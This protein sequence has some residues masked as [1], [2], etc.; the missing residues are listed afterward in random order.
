MKLIL[1]H[2]ALML[3]LKLQ[4]ERKIQK[5]LK[6]GQK[7]FFR[8]NKKFSKLDVL[9]PGKIEIFKD[10]QI[11]YSFGY[12]NPLRRKDKVSYYIFLKKAGLTYIISK[13]KGFK[14]KVID[15]FYYN[16]RKNLLYSTLLKKG[17]FGQ[18]EFPYSGHIMK[19]D[20]I[21]NFT[22][23]PI[24]PFSVHIIS[25]NNSKAFLYM[26]KKIKALG[27][28]PILSE[29]SKNNFQIK[30]KKRSLIG[31]AKWFISEYEAF[32][33]EHKIKKVNW[34]WEVNP[35]IKHSMQIEM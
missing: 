16:T 22:K 26:N 15:R 8:K 18:F 35:Q 33:M 2:Y 28:N 7:I 19:E 10:Y 31:L 17:L 30:I 6:Y 13:S 27:I 5:K 3:F 11:L 21:V 32:V 29:K 34:K 12:W 4:K 14:T 1:M 20:R 24:T 9:W 23:E 25:K